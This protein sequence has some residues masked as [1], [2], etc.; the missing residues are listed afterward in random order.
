M[1][2]TRSHSLNVGGRRLL[3]DRHYLLSDVRRV[4]GGCD[5]AWNR[6]R[7]AR[8]SNPFH[9][10]PAALQASG[11]SAQRILSRGGRWALS[12][13]RVSAPRSCA[14]GENARSRRDAWA[15]DPA[16]PLRTAARDECMDCARD[17]ARAEA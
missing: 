13:V 4:W 12:T 6:S 11:I 8:A 2:R 9:N 5:R 7:G 10:V 3:E 1:I 14:R 17:A 16:L 15:R